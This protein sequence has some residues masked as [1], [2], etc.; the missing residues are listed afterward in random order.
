MIVSGWYPELVFI[1]VGFYDST[2]LA[3]MILN[4]SVLKIYFVKLAFENQ[5]RDLSPPEKQTGPTI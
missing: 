1:S 2:N 5:F 3:V 4:S